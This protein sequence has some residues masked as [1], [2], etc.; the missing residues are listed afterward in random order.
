MPPLHAPKVLQQAWDRHKTV[1]QNYAALGLIHDLNP[2]ESGGAEIIEQDKGATVGSA[3]ESSIDSTS[4]CSSSTV[5]GTSLSHSRID[6]SDHSDGPSSA[7]LT[8]PKGHGR[9]IRDEAGNILRIELPQE[10]PEDEAPAV[11]GDV[12]MELLE[13][14]LDAS[15]RDT[16]ISDLG[17]LKTRLSTSRNTSVVKELETLSSLA[18]LSELE[19]RTT[20]SASLTGVG[21]RHTSE[22]ELAYLQRL[23]NKYKGDV[24][25]MARDRKLNTAQ[26]TAG[27]LTRALKRAGL[28][29][30]Q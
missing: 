29:A 8:L 6:T 14:Q 10:E 4:E 2:S 27:E 3:P 22:R 13:P 17:G 16:W 18:P 20:L 15:I 30:A 28:V 5:P 11:D 7:K 19:R 1:R 9:I 24:D 12:D 26:R 23:M 25:A 21:S